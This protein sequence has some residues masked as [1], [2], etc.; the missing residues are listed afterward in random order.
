[1]AGGDLAVYKDAGYSGILGLEREATAERVQDNYYRRASLGSWPGGPAPYGFSIGRLQAPNGRSVPTL[2]VNEN[3][4]IVLR[5]LEE[6]AVE[7]PVDRPSVEERLRGFRAQLEQKRSYHE[8]ILS[9]ELT[10]LN[11]QFTSLHYLSEELL[12]RA[13]GLWTQKKAA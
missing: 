6:Y 8:D 12:I 9:R 5:I 2:T 4:G 7:G 10:D 3:A 11:D 1:M 13:R